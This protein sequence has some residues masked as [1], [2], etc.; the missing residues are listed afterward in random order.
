MSITEL[1]NIQYLETFRFLHGRVTYVR[2]VESRWGS[3]KC[4]YVSLNGGKIY[5]ADKNM[6]V[7]PVGR[8]SYEKLKKLLR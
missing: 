5:S 3:K 8:I 4:K 1:V 6:M 2:L 7:I